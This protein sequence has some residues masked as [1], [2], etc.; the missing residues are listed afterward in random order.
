[1]RVAASNRAAAGKRYQR[2]ARNASAVLFT[3]GAGLC[4]GSVTLASPL[5]TAA[6][7]LA[8]SL[9]LV[10]RDAAGVA[11]RSVTPMTVYA[12]AT[13]LSSAANIT[14]LL[15]ADTDR[16]QLYFLYT[17]EEH[18][19]LAMQ[20]TLAGLLIPIAAFR[21]T[22]ALQPGG[23]ATGLLPRVY[24]VVRD[25][26]L[27]RW[28]VVIAVVVMAMRIATPLTGLGTISALIWLLPQLIVF[29]LA[30]R[31]VMIGNR[32]MVFAALG[33]AVLEALRALMFDFLR[34][35]IIA[36]VIAF[37]I[38][39][40]LGARS[41]RVVRSS[42]FLP[43]YALTALFILYFGLFGEERSRM[44]VGV[45][46]L[47]QLAELSEMEETG[48]YT[49][50]EQRQ[51]LLTR[52]T[53]FNQ[54]T[55]VARIVEEDGH[56]GGTTLEY[57]G[58]AFIPRVL[59][60]EKPKIAKGA[61][62]AL[63]IGQARVGES[64]SITNSVNMTIPGELYLNYG[65]LGVLA[66]LSIFGALLAILWDRVAFWDAMSNTLGSAFGYYL[67]W[68]GLTMAADLQIIVTLIAMYLLFIGAGWVVGSFSAP[69][70]PA[71]TVLRTTARTEDA[72]GRM[73]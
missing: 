6:G 11:W 29:A 62:F 22:L 24:G 13:A 12:F 45:G 28:G 21:A 16:R 38:G 64:G 42:F 60:P 67:L 59:W 51:T 10:A 72:V 52:L 26:T 53:T 65:W 30:R 50:G 70:S 27:F 43:I 31:G 23:T 19:L 57:L 49:P 61:W 34:S 58:Y 73:S 56:L 48:G 9:G 8:L 44:S 71:R 32:R 55:Q 54:L 47:E 37:A 15:A 18:M 40:V 35:D 66:G 39:T 7:T 41:F 4:M 5:W 69:S 25:G 33:L 68:V 17:H 1:M 2:L 63:R 14:G 3:I 46:R 20:L 36:P